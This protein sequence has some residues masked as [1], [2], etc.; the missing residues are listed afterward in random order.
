MGVSMAS[1]STY[2]TEPRDRHEA[3]SPSESSPDAAL[4]FTWRAPLIVAMLVSLALWAA[5]WAGV[6][7][8]V[9]ALLG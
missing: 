2:A 8:L 3:L 5:I 6:V 1:K 9:S 7:S 4:P